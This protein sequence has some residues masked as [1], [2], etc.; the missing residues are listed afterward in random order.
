M[1]FLFYSN[2]TLQEHI[3]PLTKNNLTVKPIHPRHVPLRRSYTTNTISPSLQPSPPCLAHELSIEQQLYFKSL[4]ESCF[5]GTEQ[6]RTDA[7]HCLSSDAALQPLLPRLL[8][9]ISQGIQTNI[10]LHDLTF[11]LQFLSILKMLTLNTF[12]SFDKYLHSIIPSLLTC[13]VCIFDMPKTNHIL[14][15]TNAN[16]YSLVWNI[17]EQASDLI[18]Y[19][20][21]KY[22]TISYFT[23]RIVSIV[24]SNLI[25]NDTNMITYSIIYACIRTL[26]LIDVQMFGSFVIDILGNYKKT[27]LLEPDFDLDYIQQQT[28]FDQ[29]IR[30]LFRKY[31]LVLEDV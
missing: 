6:Q 27:K 25:T 13:L 1:K 9:F 21:N 29:K 28:L 17:R 8:L 7:F 14:D 26:L 11:I 20:E 12:I 16:N 22:S 2:D 10:H 23:K 19:F 30:E 31:N 18:S 4:T 3:H 15:Q 24:K 5:N